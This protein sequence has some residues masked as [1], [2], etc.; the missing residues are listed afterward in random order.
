[1]Y[2]SFNS[3]FNIFIN[4]HQTPTSSNYFEVK[5]RY[6]ISYKN[7]SMAFNNIAVW[8]GVEYLHYNDHN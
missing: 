6:I 2:P 1:M 5:T 3:I 8:G 7:T 4:S